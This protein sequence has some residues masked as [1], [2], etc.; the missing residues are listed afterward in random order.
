MLAQLGPVQ[1]TVAP[2]NF[3]EQSHETGSSF[4]EHPV[5]GRRPSLE[6]VGEA[7]ERWTI[8]GKIFPQ[9][10]GGLNELEAL[11]AMSRSGEAQFFMRGDGVPMGWVAVEKVQ[12]KT[13]NIADGG[14]GR[15]IEFDVE[16][17]R[18]DAPDAAGVFNTLVS[19]F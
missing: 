15:E 4:A 2:M 12:E 9:R 7:P 1:F 8:R 14:V 13:A 16:L 6:F 18:C 17:K 3:N 19:L 10:F 5:L 11:K